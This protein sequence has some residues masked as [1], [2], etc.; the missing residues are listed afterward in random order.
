[1]HWRREWDIKPARSYKSKTGSVDFFAF[2]TCDGD[3]PQWAAMLQ[4]TAG[5]SKMSDRWY[6]KGGH[7]KSLTV[8]GL[9][10]HGKVT[11]GTPPEISPDEF[12]D[13]PPFPEFGGDNG[14]EDIGFDEDDLSFTLDM[15]EKGERMLL[16]GEA[17]LSL[18]LVQG[19]G[20][21]A[22]RDENARQKLLHLMRGEMPEWLFPE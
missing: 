12:V 6:G 1:M 21:A 17:A 4:Y 19:N 9:H 13:S 5:E 15:K 18:G 7:F 2:L 16:G 11:K 22:E 10:S 14:M 20:V 3:D 8:V